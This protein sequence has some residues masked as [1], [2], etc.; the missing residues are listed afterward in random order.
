MEESLVEN[1][2]EIAIDDDNKPVYSGD[3][4]TEVD[5]EVSASILSEFYGIK[6]NPVGVDAVKTPKFDCAFCFKEFLTPSALDNHVKVHFIPAKLSASRPGTPSLTPG[7]ENATSAVRSE[8]PPPSTKVSMTLA[9]GEIKKST[10]AKTF[11]S[12]IS[13][14]RSENFSTRKSEKPLSTVNRSQSFSVSTRTENVTA[15]EESEIPSSAVSVTVVASRSNTTRPM[16]RSEDPSEKPP[17]SGRS[18]DKST[19]ERCESFSSAKRSQNLAGS[20]PET[21]SLADHPS[22]GRSE[23]VIS[24]S[25]ML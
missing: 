2:V 25:P 19:K 23:N 16:E 22:D 4:I 1:I 15:S 14:R 20:A 9:A 10:P 18:D 21:P 7:S 13:G 17:S 24:Q 3:L 12:K 5:D 8:T 11:A 6:I